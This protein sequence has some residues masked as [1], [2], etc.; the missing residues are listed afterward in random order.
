M[1]F[2]VRPT[3]SWRQRY[4]DTITRFEGNEM[5]IKLLGEEKYN[6]LLAD[7]KLNNQ[8]IIEAYHAE[9]EF[10]IS[11]PV[12]L[13][14]LNEATQIFSDATL[15]K[16]DNLLYGALQSTGF[17]NVLLK[18]QPYAAD[19]KVYFLVNEKDFSGGDATPADFQDQ[20]RGKIIGIGSTRTAGA[21]GTVESFEIPGYGKISITASLM[22]RPF[23][24]AKGNKKHAFV[25]KVGV[26]ADH[27]IWYSAEDQ[28][29]GYQK[30]FESIF[31]YIAKDNQ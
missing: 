12:V 11:E 2:L 10:T 14:S 4:S 6:A 24:A 16:S 3:G 30:T 5:V 1:Q 31:D 15:A 22:Y 21:G 27:T 9:G 28:V 23:Q 13:H 18:D 20:Q 17:G 25:E 8:R 26:A 7:L 19:K 29:N